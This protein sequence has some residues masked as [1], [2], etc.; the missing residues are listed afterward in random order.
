M[1]GRAPV[2]GVPSIASHDPKLTS[3]RLKTLSGFVPKLLAASQGLLQPT[4]LFSERGCEPDRNPYY[5]RDRGN[6]RNIDE[7]CVI[8]TI[9][10]RAREADLLRVRPCDR[11]GR[12]GGASCLFI[13][14]ERSRCR[15][16]GCGF[17]ST[18]PAIDI[19]AES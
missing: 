14:A 3:G 4:G 1:V 19:M 2:L 12:D 17:V 11:F 9:L 18:P 6:D 8:P 10:A 7:N 15:I 5:S 13:G 16:D